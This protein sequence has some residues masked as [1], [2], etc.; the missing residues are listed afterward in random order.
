VREVFAGAGLQIIAS[1]V[2]PAKADKGFDLIPLTI[3]AEGDALALQSALTVM[4]GLKPAIVVNDLDVQLQGGL[5]AA[6]EDVAPRLTI[7]LTLSVLRERS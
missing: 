2:L 7:R 6:K 3:Q 1:Q 4:P 5:R